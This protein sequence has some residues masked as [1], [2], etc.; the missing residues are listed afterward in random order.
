MI[1]HYDIKIMQ[2]LNTLSVS[3]TTDIA[4]ALHPDADRKQ[5]I[6][7]DNKIRHRLKNLH[8]KGLVD[9]VN[10]KPANYSLNRAKVHFGNCD[11]QITNE[12]GKVFDLSFGEHVV[13]VSDEQIIIHPLDNGESATVI[14]DGKEY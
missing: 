12:H 5:I 3:T 8:S 1:D 4:K 6:N 10:S 11:L 13:I 2:F 9:F 14:M 7:K